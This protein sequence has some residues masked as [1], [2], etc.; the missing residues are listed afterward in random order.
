M[1]SDI[2]S[3]SGY[4]QIKLCGDN[5]GKTFL[6]RVILKL[7]FIVLCT[8]LTSLSTSIAYAHKLDPK[9]ASMRAEA[10]ALGDQAKAGDAQAYSTL[11]SKTIM[12]GSAPFRHNVAWIYQNGYGGPYD[13]LYGDESTNFKTKQSLKIAC[14]LYQ[15]AAEEKYPPAMHTYANL[16]L[17]PQAIHPENPDDVQAMQQARALLAESAMLGWS[18]SA[19]LLAKLTW[20]NKPDLSRYELKRLNDAIKAGFASNP[21]TSE[22]TDLSYLMAMITLSAIDKDSKDYSEHYTM[23]DSALRFAAE[24]DHEQAEQALSAMRKTWLALL[25]DSADYWSFGMSVD[26]CVSNIQSEKS[27]K[28]LASACTHNYT[29][30]RRKLDNINDGAAYLHPLI[31]GDDKAILEI[32]INALTEKSSGLQ[33]NRQTW[34][35]IVVKGYRDRI[36]AGFWRK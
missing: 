23:A 28:Y 7:R 10:N 34:D 32:S 18:S 30:Y 11:E 36:N 6:M 35:D 31:W 22:K 5:I 16:C 26:E 19:V 27:D 33:A 12:K 20:Q 21:N 17:L 1:D 8:L 2:F 9:W 4:A 29:I 14:Q 3:H 15:D 25:V 13:S 24:H